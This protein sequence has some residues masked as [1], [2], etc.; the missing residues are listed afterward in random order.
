L[1][2]AK[3]LSGKGM[4]TYILKSRRYLPRLT[5]LKI[6]ILKIG[7]VLALI[8]FELALIGFELALFFG[9]IAFFGRKTH[10]IGFVLHKKG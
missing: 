1:F 2:W 5:L 6:R 10:K 3:T 7:F 8:G 9:E 4:G